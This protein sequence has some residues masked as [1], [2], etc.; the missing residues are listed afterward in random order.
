[1]VF[2]FEIA[3]GKFVFCCFFF[4]LP[5]DS[6]IIRSYSKRILLCQDEEL[7]EDKFG[8]RKTVGK[9]TIVKALRA[10]SIMI[11]RTN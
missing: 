7:V 2:Y 1:M 5:I 6:V 8:T 11:F 3:E 9:Y 10:K 4:F